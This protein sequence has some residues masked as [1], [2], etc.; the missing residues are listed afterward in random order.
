MRPL[1]LRPARV[2]DI[3]TLQAVERDADTRFGASASP[4]DVIPE[5]AAVRAVEAGRITVAE[6]DGVV[7][8]WVFLGAI[9]GEPCIGQISVAV[10]HGRQGIGTALLTHA[11]DTARARGASSVVLNTTR[12]H[13]WNAPWYARHGFVEVPESAWSPTLRA[14]TE[15]QQAGGLDWSTRVHMRRTL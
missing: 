4:G 3:P 5:A 7:V 6:R 11:L 15:A 1:T 12:H 10:A 14:V 13:P 8:G 9:A 2:A